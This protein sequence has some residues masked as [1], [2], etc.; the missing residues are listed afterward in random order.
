MTKTKILQQLMELMLVGNSQNSQDDKMNKKLKEIFN[1][2]FI[3]GYACGRGVIDS[4]NTFY[5]FQYNHMQHINDDNIS[6]ESTDIDI[7]TIESKGKIAFFYAFPYQN[8]SSYYLY[9]VSNQQWNYYIYRCSLNSELAQN[10]I[11]KMYNGWEMNKNSFEQVL[12][13]SEAHKPF[14]EVIVIGDYISY[15]SD[16]GSYY[17]LNSG[18]S[19]NNNYIRF[20]GKEPCNLISTTHDSNITYEESEKAKEEALAWLKT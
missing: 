9:C 11:I 18:F 10:E 2:G 8:A 5:I 15:D 19:G 3:S 13:T 17:N 6:S 16:S 14:N 7:K 12:I 1:K 20:F 4:R